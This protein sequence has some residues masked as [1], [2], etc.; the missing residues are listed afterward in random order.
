VLE[1]SFKTGKSPKDIVKK[2]GLEQVSD[3]GLLE[4]VA[5][6]VIK[7]NPKAVED[8]LGGKETTIK[9]LVGQVMRETRGKANPKVV[10]EVLQKLL[11]MK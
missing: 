7:D 2:K 4:K 6:K 11:K 5:K 9:F 8:Y 10:E 3:E 1:E